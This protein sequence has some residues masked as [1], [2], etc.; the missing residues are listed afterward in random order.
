M[1]ADRANRI[2]LT[3]FGLLLVLAGAAAL[4]ASLGGFG[5]GSAHRALFAN[6]V[7]TY[8]GQHGSWLW[9]VIAVA[10]LLIALAAL[11]WI[12]ILLGSTDRAGSLPVPVAGAHGTTTLQPA[13][14]TDA[15]TEEIE[16]Y[17]GVQTAKGRIIGNPDHPRVVVTVT[18][19]P[20]ADLAELQHRIEAQALAH[21]RQ[22][23]GRTD[24][25][26]QLDLDLVR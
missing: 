17:H 23:L 19:K 14:L 1:H 8:F 25:P 11:F 10:C 9:P 15:L 3:V 5:A 2:V 21:A 16:T 24:L 13:A 4:T 22:A 20:T 6:S 26:I 18:A 12:A 7:S